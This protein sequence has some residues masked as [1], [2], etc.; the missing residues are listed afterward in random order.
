MNFQCIVE[1]FEGINFKIYFNK[2][3]NGDV[4][5]KKIYILLKNNN[6]VEVTNLEKIAIEGLKDLI[7]DE[8]ES[9]PFMDSTVRVS[10]DFPN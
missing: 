2:K 8:I 9:I 10:L 4:D 6:S 7:N 1:V 3:N 5:I